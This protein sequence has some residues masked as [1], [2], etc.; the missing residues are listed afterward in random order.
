MKKWMVLTICTAAMSAGVAMA[1]LP[2]VLV[3]VD[4]KSLGSI[5]TSEVEAM[6]VELL[7]EKEVETV[8]QDMLSANLERTR[9]AVK[10]AGDGRGAAALGREFGADVVLLGEAVAKPSA[11]RIAGSNLR[12]YQAVV[13]LRAVRT[14]TAVNMAASSE[15]ATVVSLE[16]VEGGSKALKAAGRKSLDSIIPA[17]LKK[18]EKTGAQ[19]ESSTNAVPVK[20][21]LDISV[22]GVD[23][24][25]KLKAV[26]E[27]MRS[28]GGVD[29][30]SQRSYAQG[31]A[32]FRAVSL[33]P[34]EELAE[35]V[36]MDPPEDLKMQVVEIKPGSLT[37]RVVEVPADVEE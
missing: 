19:G 1:T 28:M 26:R 34:S 21:N 20:I 16:D 25:W 35:S 8:D 29:S 33:V 30:V 7:G 18:W 4:E 3:L 31:L 27:K 6:A 9:S 11:K 2:K 12:S 37:L 13:T 36:V 32:V 22:G 10:G 15:S 5:A 17:M 24:M 23:Q 14:D